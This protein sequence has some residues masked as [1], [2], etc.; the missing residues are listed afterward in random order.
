MLRAN[1]HAGPDQVALVTITAPGADVLPWDGDHVEA[2]AA[3]IWN[4]TAAER[5]SKLN[6]AC[7]ERL[8]RADLKSPL[9]SYVWQLQ[10][11]GVL[12]AHLVLDFGHDD[13]K[14]ATYAYV[15]ALRDLATEYGFGF[16][17]FRDR[18]GRAGRSSVMPRRVAAGYLSRYA[19]KGGQLAEAAAL[20]ARAR[21][22]RLLYVSRRLT[23]VSLCTMRRLRS[24]RFLYWIR[25]GNSSVLFARAGRLPDWF[26]DPTE[27]GAVCAL[28]QA[29]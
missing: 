21:P 11:R 20:P 29:P 4:R 8:R 3:V 27:Y 23:A 1:L 15:Q 19:A 26:G 18:D 6:R 9:L 10:R 16:I 7:R 14:A 2:T 12:H 28:A 5:W 13:D 22:R 25:S 24:V 17:D